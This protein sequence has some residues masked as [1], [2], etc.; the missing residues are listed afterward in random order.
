M[1]QNNSETLIIRK[2][3]IEFNCFNKI[4]ANTREIIEFN[5]GKKCTSSTALHIRVDGL[6]TFPQAF[7]CQDLN[8]IKKNQKSLTANIK[9]YTKI[10]L[11]KNF[12]FISLL[13]EMIETL[14]TIEF[15]TPIFEFNCF[16]A[17]QLYDDH[18]GVATRRLAAYI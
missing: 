5:N 18:L 15:K 2:N 1:L 7:S 10:S 12:P 6:K 16:K 8:P 17:A 13:L 11:F 3:V 14:E 4:F 9:N